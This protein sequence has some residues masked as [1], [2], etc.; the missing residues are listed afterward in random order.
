MRGAHTV[1][2]RIAQARKDQGRTQAQLAK[3]CGSCVRTV[4]YWESEQV[5]PPYPALLRVADALDIE[6]AWFYQREEVMP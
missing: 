1:G 3:A 4:Q 2:R 5:H 6:L